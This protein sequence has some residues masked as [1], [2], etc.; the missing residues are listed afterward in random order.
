MPITRSGDAGISQRTT[1]YAE[2]VA[3]KHAPPVMVLAKFATP[4]RMPANKGT[5]IKFRRPKTFAAVLTPLVEG[6]TPN[7][8]VFE[9][10]DVS[11]SLKQYGM[12]GGIT[13]VV[14]DTHEDPVLNDMAAMMGENIG[15]TQE[16]LN[17]GV[18]KAGTQVMYANGAARANV[19]TVLTISKQRAAIRTLKNQ[20]GMKITSILGGSPDHN[21]TPIEA[22]YIAVAHTD[23]DSDIRNLP[24]FVPTSEYGTRQTIAPEE[25]GSVEDVR[26]ILSAD[27]TPFL[28]AGG[29][30]GGTVVSTG[31]S[32]ADVYP[33]LY[34]A[35][36]AYAA[37]SVRGAGSVEV[38]IIP[39]GQKTKDDPLGQRGYAGWKFWW[40]GLITNQAWMVRLEVAAT[41]L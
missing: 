30:Y 36:D 33:I 1:T 23:L 13:D 5:N 28:N 4:V 24:G 12:V 21:T 35:K 27:L 26:Y 31:A 40:A 17:Y 37:V 18:M 34:L 41:A 3:L 11:T 14:E 32:A 2:R 10:E 15:R 29:A 7:T 38:S 8:T 6:V 39:V 25:I 22:A 16:A 9:Y 19:N 20:K